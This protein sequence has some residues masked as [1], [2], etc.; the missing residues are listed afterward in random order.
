MLQSGLAQTDTCDTRMDVRIKG[1]SN[2]G[3]LEVCWIINNSGPRWW[4]ICGYYDLYDNNWIGYW[5]EIEAGIVCRQLN[6]TDPS[7]QGS[8]IS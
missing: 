4:P 3:P 6:F 5:S 1:K 7:Y 8:Y 2:V